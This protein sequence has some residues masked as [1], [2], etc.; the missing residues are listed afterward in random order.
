MPQIDIKATMHGPFFSLGAA[1]VVKAV[2][3]AVREAVAE[4]E[5][6][7]GL[8]LYPGHGFKLGHYKRSVHGEMQSSLHGRIHD[9][10]VVYG[11]W[12]EGVSSRNQRTRFKGYA[13]FRNATQQLKR[14]APQI[15]KKHIDRAVKDLD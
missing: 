11:P 5:H 8:Q 15:L 9:S 13:M 10:R 12:L 2:S 4:G 6:R 3:S 14:L 1:P 7:V